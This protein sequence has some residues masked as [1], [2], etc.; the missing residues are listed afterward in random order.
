MEVC[1]S[2]T[3]RRV[4]LV[5]IQIFEEQCT[6]HNFFFFFEPVTTHLLRDTDVVRAPY[7]QFAD[8]FVHWNDMIRE[9]KATR[10]LNS[11]SPLIF[12]FF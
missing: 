8:R 10:Q 11:A 5:A 6:T 3:T 9:T 2:K 4:W 7:Q 12:F 1:L